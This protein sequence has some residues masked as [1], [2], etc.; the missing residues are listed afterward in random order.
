MI[1][2]NTSSRRSNTN[3][4]TFGTTAFTFGTTAFGVAVRA[5]SAVDVLRKLANRSSTDFLA[6]VF[7]G[8]L[9]V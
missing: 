1:G 2:V 8:V 7:A 4:S 6:G 3:P 9:D 5:I